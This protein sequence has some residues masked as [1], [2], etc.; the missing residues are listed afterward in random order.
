MYLLHRTK[1][2]KNKHPG[3]PS[4]RRP[5]IDPSNTR[6]TPLQ[7]RPDEVKK[8][9]RTFILGSSDGPDGLMP[10]QCSHCSRNLIAGDDVGRL[11]NARMDIANLMLAGKFDTE[12]NTIISGGRLIAL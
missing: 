10:Q 7:I 1:T 11:L 6:F 8:A 12:I 5:P 9:L 4:D 3:P 2:L